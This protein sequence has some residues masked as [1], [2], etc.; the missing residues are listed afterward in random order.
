VQLSSRFVASLLASVFGPSFYDGPRF[1][2]G[3]LGRR[4][5]SDLVTGPSPE[6]WRAVMLNPQ[7]LPPKEHYALSLA[8]AH[9]NELLTFDRIGSLLGGE[10]AERSQERGLRIVAEIDELCPRWPRWPRGVWPPP[11]PPPWGQEEMNPAALF[12]FGI[13]LLGAAELMEQGR[14]QDSVGK[15]AEKALEL[16]QAG[17][18]G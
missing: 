5:L 11:P 1:G 9:I 14:L 2:R 3:D 17:Q 16:S 10:A 6:P 13:R 12:L 18:T 8:D 7:P 15:L 4:G